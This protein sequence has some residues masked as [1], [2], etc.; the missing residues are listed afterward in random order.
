MTDPGFSLLT[1]AARSD[2]VRLRTL[3]MLR[4][5]AIVGQTATIVVS[6]A[7]LQLSLPLNLCAVAIAASVA[8]NI[9]STLVHPENKRLSERDTALTLLFDLMQ[10][11]VLLFATGGLTNP[12]AV[13]VLAP[14][15]ISATAL[16]LRAT[17]ALAGAALA[18]IT[19]L[20]LVHLPLRFADGAS[21]DLPDI[22]LAGIWVALLIAIV[23][24]AL[25]ARR[26]TLE[27]FSMSQALIATQMALARE[28]RLTALGGLVA[29]TA[30]ELGTP[31]ATIKL[32]AA[33]LAHELRDR[34][35]LNEDVALIREQ[36]DRCRD[37]LRSLGR[38]GKDDR[39]MRSAPV[40]AVVEEAAEPHRERGKTMILRIVGSVAGSGSTPN[41]PMI[42]RHPEIIHGLRNLVQNAV[43]FA[44]DHVWIDIGWDDSELRIAVGDDGPGYPEDMVGRLGDPFVRRRAEMPIPSAERPG[45][46]GMG[47]GLFIAKTLLERMGA[48]VTFANGSEGRL[49][50]GLHATADPKIARPPGAIVEVIWPRA[51][52]EATHESVR[53]PL[54]A[55]PPFANLAN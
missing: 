40:E 9:V 49:L 33:E 41:Q 26:V 4:W 54:G 50:P 5:L 43:D 11:S 29:A 51:I 15:T 1:N 17:L 16:T 45:Y 25:Y 23:F 35:D 31:L 22:Y 27:A 32:T 2:W 52:L 38:A 8:F 30:H 24:L 12:F 14:V 46:E 37:I 55:N 47:L 20:A 44:K 21:F 10:L 19:L 53:G 39:H 34:P 13:L 7:V 28:Q 36:T 6:D 18:L 42:I 48:Q 3:I